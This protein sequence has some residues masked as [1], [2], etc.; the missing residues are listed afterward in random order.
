[1]AKDD[2]KR[3]M[4]VKM[5]D[6]TFDKIQAFYIDP[7]LYPLTPSVE[8][9]RQRWVF[10]NSLLHKAFPKYKIVNALVKDYS[11]SQPQA[12]VDIRNTESLFGNMHQSS[13]E[14]EKAMWKDWVLDLARRA[15]KKGDFKTE[16][17]AYDMFAKYSDF[18]AEELTFNPEKLLNKEIHISIDSNLLSAINKA[19]SGGVVDFNNLDVTDVEI[20]SD[21]ANSTTEEDC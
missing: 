13:K 16:A 17:K 8:E 19:N 12:Y 7:E 4:L 10:I 14:V 18:D 6:T 3:P 1:M 11:I 15:R 2:S 20:I 21:D 5:G 9:I